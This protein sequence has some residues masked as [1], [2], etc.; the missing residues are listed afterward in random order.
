MKS[1]PLS[2]VYGLLL[3][4]WLSPVFTTNLYAENYTVGTSAEL[5]NALSDMPLGLS[6]HITLTADISFYG[7]IYMN[8]GTK[9]TFHLAGHILTVNGLTRADMLSEIKI[10]DA[11]AGSVL[12]AFGG[13]M[14]N[15][16]GSSVTVTNA[17]DPAYYQ[18]PA[19]AY[20]GG[21]ILIKGYLHSAHETAIQC[22]GKDDHGK[23]SSV[24]IDG[25]VISSY[26]GNCVIADD[27]GTINIHG[28]LQ[29]ASSG[30]MADYAGQITI[31]GNVDCGIGYGVYAKRA[32]TIIVNGVITAPL[33]IALVSS[34][35]PP[36]NQ[37]VQDGYTIY[38]RSGADVS[39]VKVKIQGATQPPTVIT[40]MPSAIT[41]GQAAVTGEISSDGGASV[42]ERGFVYG[43]AVNPTTADNKVTAGSGTGIFNGMLVGLTEN[44]PY[45]V[46]AYGTNSAGTA[47]GEDKA[48]T[49]LSTGTLAV[50]ATTLNIAAANGST[51][52]FDITSNISWNVTAS[53]AWL[54]PSPGSGNGNSSITV[55]ATAN[56]LTIPRTATV[57]VSGN[58]VADHT[59]TVTQS[60]G[61]PEEI[62]CLSFVLTNEGDDRMIDRLT[63]S[64]CTN[65]YQAMIYLR[66]HMAGDAPARL[67]SQ[68]DFLI[69]EVMNFPAGEVFTASLSQFT[70]AGNSP[71][72]IN[73]DG[74]IK[75]ADFTVYNYDGQPGF[76]RYTGDYLFTYSESDDQNIFLGASEID[77]G[78]G[79]V[80]I[81]RYSAFAVAWN[82]VSAIT[83]EAAATDDTAILQIDNK[84][85]S[86]RNK[87]WEITLSTGTVKADVSL[88]DL[89]MTGLPNGFSC[90]AE[91][92]AGNDI[93]IALS[94]TAPFAITNDHQVS[95]VVRG[96]AVTETGS[97]DSEA[98]TLNLWSTGPGTTFVLTNEGGLIDKLI[99]SGKGSM[100]LHE[101]LEFLK[102]ASG[103]IITD[104]FLKTLESTPAGGEVFHQT[105]GN[106]TGSNNPVCINIDGSLRINDIF[107]NDY[108]KAP[109]Y[110]SFSI[111]LA[112]IGRIRCT[113]P[114]RADN[115]IDA[116]ERMGQRYLA[117]A[118]AWIYEPA[119]SI[120]ANSS[121]PVSIYPNPC[122]DGFHVNGLQAPATLYLYDMSGKIVGHEV[123][124]GDAYISMG[125]LSRGFY[126]C[127][128]RLGSID[129][130]SRIVKN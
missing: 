78:G 88:S 83:V 104:R 38:T 43:L 19:G 34:D 33:P 51:N 107:G 93:V 112:S 80:K 8:R 54:S 28:N 89:A 56:P 98:I 122:T 95:V 39:M 94:G 36:T 116:G 97:Q 130:K 46:R 7:D 4:I 119:S 16:R 69:T 128:I 65:L 110:N 86:A 82:M 53:Q 32:S 70:G 72:G 91:K 12:N 11:Q 30:A 42:S 129:W 52:T 113:T 26:D 114:D 35:L 121:A 62:D 109:G 85:P 74:T 115:Y 37:T 96:S 108:D 18:V 127:R 13:I 48:F 5:G 15:S 84:T 6:S 41:S 73:A 14:V 44:T 68:L 27:S 75:R 66:N 60:A 102:P 90:T 123:L 31:D 79:V 111:Q 124:N 24:T 40:G 101:L 2:A 92:G 105:L 23:P 17:A 57:T 29:S 126:F 20:D 64:G 117:F 9:V 25:D 118:I 103:D 67:T 21:T 58:G 47:Y 100:N 45:H 55:T 99:A 63:E 10:D 50:S 3:V 61:T 1:K 22:Y 81:V 59:I 71:V 125:T 87:T 76:K 120:N 49:T 77:L 106:F